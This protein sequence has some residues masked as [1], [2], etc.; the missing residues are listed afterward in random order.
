MLE[1]VEGKSGKRKKW[2]D[3]DDSPGIE[4]PWQMSALSECSYFYLI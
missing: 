4:L 3:F 2:V 1:I